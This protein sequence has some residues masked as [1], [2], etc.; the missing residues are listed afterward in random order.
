VRIL[1]GRYALENVKHEPDGGDVVIY[2]PKGDG[3]EQRLAYRFTQWQA[4]Y[5]AVHPILTED[6]RQ[7]RFPSDWPT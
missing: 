4:R 7:G 2:L 1:A 6:I 5:L 3:A